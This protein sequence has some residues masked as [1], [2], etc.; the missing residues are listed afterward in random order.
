MSLTLGN[1]AEMFT[2]LRQAVDATRYDSMTIDLSDPTIR[3]QF[4]CAY[5][6]QVLQL[7]ENREAQTATVDN[8]VTLS[9]VGDNG[10]LQVSFGKGEDPIYLNQGGETLRYFEQLGGEGVALVADGTTPQDALNTLSG[11]PG[12]VLDF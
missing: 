12:G 10:A 8:L 2:S 4:D 11:Q 6:Q 9:T 1:G 3:N 5:G 7:L